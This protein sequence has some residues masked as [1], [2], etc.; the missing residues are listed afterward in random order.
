MTSVESSVRIIGA[1]SIRASVTFEDL[2]EPVSRAFEESSAGLADNGLVVMFPAERRELGDVYVKTGSLAVMTS[3]SS[4]CRP[5]SAQC[6]TGNPRADLSAFSTATPGEPSPCWTTSTTCPISGPP[7]PEH[8]PRDGLRRPTSRPPPCSAR[9]CRRTGSPWR[10]TANARSGPCRSGRET[11][12]G[13]AS[14]DP[15]EPELPDVEIRCSSDIE[16]TVRSADVLITA[17]LARE[18]LVRGRG[19]TR[20]AHHRGRRR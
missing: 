13:R 2:V 6:R 11:C 4:R 16:R 18:P 15:A 12:E 5:G 14:Q 3:I 17:T 1:D 10:C 7:P 19:C 8:L 20:H 9:V